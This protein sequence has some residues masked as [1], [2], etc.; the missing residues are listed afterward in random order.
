MRV[1]RVLAILGGALTVAAC[2]G[3]EAAEKAKHQSERFY[4]AASIAF[5]DEHDVL[6]AIRNLTR[7]VE[8]DPDNGDARYL[9]GIIRLGRGELDEAE[10][11]LREAIRIRTELD[12]RAGLSGAQNN[13]GVLL[14][15]RKQYQEAATVLQAASGEVMNREPWL[16]QGN[17]GWAYIEL[18]EYDKAIEVLRR[19][20]FDQPKFCVGLFRLGQAYYM[21]QE[22]EAA[23]A[24]LEQALAVPEKGCDAIQ[25]AHRYLGMTFVRRGQDEEAEGAFDRC[26]EIAPATEVGV[27]CAEARSSL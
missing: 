25:E 17:L 22:Y 6:A 24:A 10:K 14:I 26:V 3:T 2:G 15:H 1:M 27:A 13:L 23:K 21:K 4:E 8:A 20:M 9:L 5:F 18:G 11:H 7:A 19:A 12:D 16:A